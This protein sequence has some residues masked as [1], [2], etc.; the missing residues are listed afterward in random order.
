MQATEAGSSYNTR[1]FARFSEVLVKCQIQKNVNRDKAL[2]TF[3]YLST[4]IS[5]VF[6]SSII[7]SQNNLLAFNYESHEKS[8]TLD[9][10]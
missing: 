6:T 2:D 1:D 5:P 9:Q 7:N 10:R 3:L 8:L 4:E